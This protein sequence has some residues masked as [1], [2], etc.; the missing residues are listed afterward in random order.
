MKVEKMVPEVYY[1]ESRDFAYIGRLLEIIFNYMKTA[2]DCVNVGFNNENIDANCVDLIADTLGFDS[3]HKYITKDLIFVVSAF[4]KLLRQKGTSEAINLAIR[5]LLNSQGIKKSAD[6]NFVENSALN[7]LEI[8]IPDDLTDIILL[9]D[10][11]DYI[12]PVG[13]TYKFTRVS[14]GDSKQESKYEISSTVEIK[15]SVTET[16]DNQLGI[17]ATEESLT[18]DAETNIGTIAT[19]VVYGSTENTD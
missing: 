7:E 6:F 18:D 19:G 11:F 5:L 8:K 12:L 17:V 3:K 13:T 2:S 10:L 1:K 16:S 4:S 15:H 9:E 14:I